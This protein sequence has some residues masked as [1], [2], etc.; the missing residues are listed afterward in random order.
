MFPKGNSKEAW[1]ILFLK[2]RMSLFSEMTGKTESKYDRT[3][4]D[5]QGSLAR[6]DVEVE[7]LSYHSCS[8]LNRPCFS[9]WF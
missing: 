7:T 4:A 1:G 3:P 6:T 5:L 2:L 9:Y 8:E